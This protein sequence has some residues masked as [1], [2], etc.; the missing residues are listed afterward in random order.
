MVLTTFLRTLSEPARIAV[1]GEP[2]RTCLNAIRSVWQSG[3]IPFPILPS[4][5]RYLTHLL[6]EARAAAVLTD[7]GSSEL[8]RASG[9]NIGVPVLEMSETPV[10]LSVPSGSVVFEGR[11]YLTSVPLAAMISSSSWEG[12]VEVNKRVLGSM[13]SSNCVSL[14]R[15]WLLDAYSFEKGLVFPCTQNP[16]APTFLVADLASLDRMSRLVEMGAISPSSVQAFVLDMPFDDERVRMGKLENLISGFLKSGQEILLRFST[17]ETGPV[18]QLQR[19]EEFGAPLKPI[20]EQ[21]L[22][23]TQSGA[24][25]VSRNSATHFSLYLNREDKLSDDVSREFTSSMLITPEPLADR[26]SFSRKRKIMQ[27]D[28]RVRQVPLAVYHKKRGFKGQIY[29]TTKHKGWTLYKSRY[30]N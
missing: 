28:W 3:H 7:A 20:E 14:G 9:R 12:Q 10:A 18:A 24:L 21:Q 30:Y 4:R 17:P 2:S 27:P 29:Y 19:L 8:A 25:Q 13:S 15:N 23:V 16:P 1:L 26:K 22:T 11:S 6:V 5:G